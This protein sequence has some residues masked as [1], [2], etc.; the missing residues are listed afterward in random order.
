MILFSQ[1]SLQ[2][3]A[4]LLS[5]IKK[6]KNKLYRIISTFELVDGRYYSCKNIVFGF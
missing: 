6:L 2:M 4:E 1:F 5:R 3:T